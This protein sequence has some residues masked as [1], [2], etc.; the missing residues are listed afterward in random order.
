[1]LRGADG[2]VVSGQRIK[3]IIH[4]ALSLLGQTNTL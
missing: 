1:V 2:S 4:Y 3:L